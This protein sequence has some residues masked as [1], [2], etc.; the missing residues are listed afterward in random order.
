MAARLRWWMIPAALVVLARVV[1]L[2]EPAEPAEPAPPAAAA[3]PASAARSAAPMVETLAGPVV[4]RDAA[5]QRRGPLALPADPLVLRLPAEAAGQR[6]VLSVFCRDGGARA[7]APV[8]R[9]T[10]LVSADGIVPI[11][12]LCAGRC[13]VEVEFGTGPAVQRLCAEDVVVPGTVDLRARR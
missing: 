9:A 13:D 6:V 4:V 2:G 5:G 10:P 3:V 11:G 8:L 12:G 1:T 7:M